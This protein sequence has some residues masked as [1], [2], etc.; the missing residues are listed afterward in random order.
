MRTLICCACGGPAPGKQWR[1]RDTGFGVCARC[2]AEWV[3][4]YGLRDSCESCGFPGVHHS[5]GAA[6]PWFCVGEDTVLAEQFVAE[7]EAMAARAD[8]TPG[9]VY[10]LWRRYSAECQ[11]ADQSAILSEFLE[12]YKGDLCQTTTH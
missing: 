11:S 8:K 5:P 4:R 12:W 2:F 3:K 10:A 1:N 6:A 9:Q 7:I